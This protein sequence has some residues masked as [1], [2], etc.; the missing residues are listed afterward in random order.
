MSY[1]PGASANIWKAYYPNADVHFLEYDGDCVEKWQK[2]IDAKGI[3]VH[4][5]DQADVNLWSRLLNK[6][7]NNTYKFGA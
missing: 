5:G 7:L 3:N 2:E 1:G 4:V 6:N